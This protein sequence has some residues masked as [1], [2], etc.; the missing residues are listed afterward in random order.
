MRDHWGQGIGTTAK[1]WFDDQPCKHPGMVKRALAALVWFV[2]TDT[3]FNMVALLIGAPEFL[4]L[5]VA[6]G[7]SAFIF[8]GPMNVLPNKGKVEANARPVTVNAVRRP[9]RPNY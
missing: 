7:V 5:I 1:W 6:G 3:A 8:V 4:G 2:V 9:V